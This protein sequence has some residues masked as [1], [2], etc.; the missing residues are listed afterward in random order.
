MFGY[1]YMIWQFIVR[2]LEEKN[3]SFNA[4]NA[5]LFHIGGWKN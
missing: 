3:I 1:T 5:V 4:E 2:A